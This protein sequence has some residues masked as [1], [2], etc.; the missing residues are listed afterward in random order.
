MKFN[1]NVLLI[2]A[3]T[4]FVL[5]CTNTSKTKASPEEK[6]INH[7]I[8]SLEKLLK[9]NDSIQNVVPKKLTK[10]EE[11]DTMRSRTL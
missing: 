10:K 9:K 8:D 5:S 7:K 2:A 11:L 3:A 1:P 6:I 4:A